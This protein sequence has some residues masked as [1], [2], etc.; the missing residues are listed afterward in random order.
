M[1]KTFRTNL[2]SHPLRSS[3]PSVA[4][5]RRHSPASGR[6]PLTK[7]VTQLALRS[8]R[9]SNGALVSA[10]GAAIRLRRP[11]GLH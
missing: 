7:S 1:V 9:R 3:D 2:P 4:R 5:R 6:G 8:F 10:A 11:G